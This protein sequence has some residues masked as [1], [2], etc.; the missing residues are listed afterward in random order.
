MLA[1]GKRNRLNLFGRADGRF[2]SLNLPVCTRKEIFVCYVTKDLT[3]E[4]RKGEGERER[5]REHCPLVSTK[6]WF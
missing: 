2:K 1:I 6:N 3:K 4:L 5:E